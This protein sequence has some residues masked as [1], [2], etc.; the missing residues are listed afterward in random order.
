[1]DNQILDIASQVTLSIIGGYLVLQLIA[2]FKA[3]YSKREVRLE[4][5][6]AKVIRQDKCIAQYLKD[7]Y[8]LKDITREAIIQVSKARIKGLNGQMK[9]VL[10]RFDH[11]EN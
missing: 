9:K 7:F 3:H 6:E 11:W 1:M 10:A 5:L 2:W 4:A 8:E